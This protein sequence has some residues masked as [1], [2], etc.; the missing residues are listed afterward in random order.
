MYV[1][2]QYQKHIV[3]Y[4][5]VDT[6]DIQ[7]AARIIYH[8][9]FKYL[10]YSIAEYFYDILLICPK[11]LIWPGNRPTFLLFLL[12]IYNQKCILFYQEQNNNRGL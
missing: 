5:D 3:L 9:F 10:I 11:G 12:W 7:N 8:P 4:K 2:P 1:C 6:T